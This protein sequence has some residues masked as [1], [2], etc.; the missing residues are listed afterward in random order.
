MAFIVAT[1]TMVCF[2]WA[3]F[4]HVIPQ[5]KSYVTSYDTAQILPNVYDDHSQLYIEKFLRPGIT[6]YSGKSGEEWDPVKNPELDTLLTQ[7]EKIFLIMSKATFHKLTK[8][9]PLID[10]FGIA[11]ETPSQVILINHP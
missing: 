7:D 6:Y 4:G 9:K 10:R 5:L 8:S 1:A 3:I 2:S 11:G